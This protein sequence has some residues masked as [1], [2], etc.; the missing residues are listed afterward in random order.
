MAVALYLVGSV[1]NPT[2]NEWVLNIEKNC[3]KINPNQSISPE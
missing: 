1:I 3:G 2:P